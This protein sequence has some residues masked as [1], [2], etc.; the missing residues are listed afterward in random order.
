VSRKA[1]RGG[2]AFGA[3]LAASLAALPPASA[4]DPSSVTLPTVL[5]AGLLDG[6]MPCSF[7]LLLLFVSYTVAQVKVNAASAGRE[8]GL[9]ETRLRLLLI[10]GVF[11]LGIY[12]AYFALG[13][14]FLG[15]SAWLAQGHLIGKA[16]AILVIAVGFLAL[17]PL[18][19]PEFNFSLAMPT[20]LHRFAEGKLKA[21]TVPAAFAGGVL[22]ALCAVPCSGTVYL[23]VLALVSAT[24]T[25]WQGVGYLALYNLMFVAPLLVV[26]GLAAN[27]PSFNRIAHFRHAHYETMGALM[28]VVMVGLGLLTL[29]LLS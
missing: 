13:L 17:A 22:I 5:G 9:S 23:G 20:F 29:F 21:A 4:F 10:G 7:A 1:A 18:A 6:F 26:L 14:G 2:A 25:A 24:T 12:L 15:S 11:I 19:F 8:A 16:A 3:A 27:R 28:G